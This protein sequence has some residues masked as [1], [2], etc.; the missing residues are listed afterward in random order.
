MRTHHNVMSGHIGDI[1]PM[2]EKQKVTRA[3]ADVDDQ[4]HSALGGAAMASAAISF[5]ALMFWP[6]P[7]LAFSLR[8]GKLVAA[9]DRPTPPAGAERFLR[10]CERLLERSP[11][12]ARARGYRFYVTNA[13]W[14][15]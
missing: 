9:S 14:L 7:L 3:G 4:T 15:T 13:D 8:A 10:D 12:K 1:H 6:D 5:G 11:L 2:V